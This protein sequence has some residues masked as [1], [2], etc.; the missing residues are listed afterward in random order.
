MLAISVQ[1]EPQRIQNLRTSRSHC[2]EGKISAKIYT[3]GVFG[4]ENE[5]ISTN[6]GGSRT[7]NTLNIRI[8]RK[9]WNKR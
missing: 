5:S 3:F 8:E 9:S 2:I 6:G 4:V 1:L 7:G